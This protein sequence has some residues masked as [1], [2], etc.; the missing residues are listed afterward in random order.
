MDISSMG[1]Y[2]KRGLK[3][4][5]DFVLGT[6]NEP[7][8]KALQDTV[9]NRGSQNYFSSVWEGTKKG[10]LASEEHNAKMLKRDG[11]FFKSTWKALKTTPHKIS[12]GWKVGG[13]LA[14]KAGKTGLSKFWAKTKGA[15]G[16]LGKRMPLVGTLLV[17]VTEIPNLFS[18]FKDL[19]LVGGVLETGKT[20]LRLGA[21]MTCAAIGQALVPIPGIGA[22]IGGL[23]GYMAGDWIMSKIVGKSYSEKQAEAAEKQQAMVQNSEQQGMQIPQTGLANSSNQIAQSTNVPQLNIPAPTATEQD[24]MLM[25][26]QLYGSS[27]AMSD[28][29]MANMSGLSNPFGKMN[30]IC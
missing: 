23:V 6:G 2:I 24:L 27:N 25:K 20:G 13:Q 12:Q 17:A 1:S 18:A 5:P 19:G 29:F 4:Y 7:F 26:Q 10:F 22:L 30:Y 14:E 15:L 11:N 8:V 21:G 9:K 28:D 16:G 3:M